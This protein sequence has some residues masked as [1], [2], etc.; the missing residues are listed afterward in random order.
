MG[1]KRPSC[2]PDIY[3]APRAEA[4]TPKDLNAPTEIGLFGQGRRTWGRQPRPWLC[5]PNIAAGSHD[6]WIK[7]SKGIRECRLTKI[8]LGLQP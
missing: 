7:H 1:S 8:P 6:G 2:L 3:W 5:G 4:A